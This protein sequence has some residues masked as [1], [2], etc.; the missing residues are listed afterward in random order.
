[1]ASMPGRS[2]FRR[3]GNGP[4]IGNCSPPNRS[5]N[6]SV[7]S[8]LAKQ[9]TT[10]RRSSRRR[11]CVRGS[12]DEA[13]S[14]VNIALLF[15]RPCT[16]FPGRRRPFRGDIHFPVRS[17]N[18]CV[19]FSVDLLRRPYPL[20]ALRYLQARCRPRVLGALFARRHR[21][22]GPMLQPFLQRKDVPNAKPGN[23]PR[24]G[25]EMRARR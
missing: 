9:N 8:A 15:V 11:E 14:A 2:R 1:M 25:S 21:A 18:C 5:Q 7:S 17:G 20:S 10:N 4:D 12:A 16:F 23:L 24:E 19:R 22:P 6:A 3:D 13:A